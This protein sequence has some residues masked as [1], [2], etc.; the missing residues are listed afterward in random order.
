M[1]DLITDPIQTRQAL[2]T[3]QRPLEQ[4]GSRDRFAVAEL[5]QCEGGVAF[6]Y[7]DEDNLAP[8]M[9]AGFHG[10]PG[11][12][13]GDAH[14]ADTALDV[15][16]RRLPPRN[17]PDFHE[18]L[19]TFGLSPQADFSDLSLLAYTGARMTGDSFGIT[20][21][22]EGFDRPFRYVFDVS[23]YRHY[24]DGAPDLAIDEPVGFRH[25]STNEHD[26]DAVEVTRQDGVRLGYVNRLQA[27]KVRGWI[28]RGS[29]D[30]RVFGLGGRSSY[31]RLFVMADIEPAL[32][33][34]HAA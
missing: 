27:Q 13:L 17:R 33:R 22:F 4:P 15:L 7:L 2:L 9:E 32:Q 24:R 21:T 30:A 25:D 20:E 12:A 23:G 16:I 18:F 5:L 34:V 10:Y 8:A 14:G 19:E 26:P 6:S 11:L 29:I 28:A 3:W 1:T 31:P